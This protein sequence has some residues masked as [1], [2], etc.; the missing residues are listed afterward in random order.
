L[1]VLREHNIPIDFIAGTSAGS[2]AGGALAS[3]LS[4]EEIVEMSRKLVGFR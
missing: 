4:I 1:K 3:G 2:I